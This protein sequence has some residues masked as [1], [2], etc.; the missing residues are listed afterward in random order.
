MPQDREPN[1]YELKR[2]YAKCD[3]EYCYKTGCPKVLK[4]NIMTEYLGR[5]YSDQCLTH[6]M[7]DDINDTNMFKENNE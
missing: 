7:K 5:W 2:G 4:E 3:G 1:L 6:L